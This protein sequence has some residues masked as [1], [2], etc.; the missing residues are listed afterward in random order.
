MR[1]GMETLDE[2]LMEMLDEIGM[3]FRRLPA[4]HG[5]HGSSPPG[6]V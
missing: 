4:D 3:V 5:A 1:L 2:V 6:T